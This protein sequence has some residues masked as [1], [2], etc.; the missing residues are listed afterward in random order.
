MQVTNL[1]VRFKADEDPELIEVLAEEIC[2]HIKK[3]QVDQ[4][5]SILA[6]LRHTLSPTVLEVYKVVNQE[7]S[8]RLHD[9][10]NSK[11][12]NLYVKPEDL[13]KILTLLLDHN[14]MSEEMKHAF[15]HY[16]EM[17]LDSLNYE[18]L[19]E[20]AVIHAAK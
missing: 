2:K 17:N 7:F 14:Q 19:S 4:I 3:F 10:Y 12:A 20:M 16:L 11:D 1:L 6:N 13:I 9:G 8:E 15:N 5:L 18:W